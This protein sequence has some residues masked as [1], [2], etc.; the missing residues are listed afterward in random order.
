[1]ESLILDVRVGVL[2]LAI[3]DRVMLHLG[4]GADT[5]EAVDLRCDHFAAQVRIFT[6]G[7][8]VAAPVGDPV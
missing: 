6:V 8:Q 3:V 2:I 7:R 5:L 1:M 4:H